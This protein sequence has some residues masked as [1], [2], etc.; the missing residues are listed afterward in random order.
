MAKSKILCKPS[1]MFLFV[2]ELSATVLH[3]ETIF[4]KP[5]FVSGQ[6]DS[7]HLSKTNKSVQYW[8]HYGFGKELAT[9]WMRNKGSNSRTFWG[10]PRQ[11]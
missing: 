4:T 3:E 5:S 10:E 1:G 11:E 6:W 2:L 7:S 8:S 9:N